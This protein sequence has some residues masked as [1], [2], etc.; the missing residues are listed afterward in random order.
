MPGQG[1]K[2]QGVGGTVL[3]DARVTQ[4]DGRIWGAEEALS[5]VPSVC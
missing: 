2:A 5:Q 4:G 3:V 1:V